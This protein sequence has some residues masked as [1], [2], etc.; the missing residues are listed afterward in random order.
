MSDDL[1]YKI[2]LDGSQAGATL[3]SLL[4]GVSGLGGALA[5]LGVAA[6][7]SALVRRGMDFNRTMADSEVAISNVLQQMAGLNAESAK[8]E[9]AKAMQQLIDLEPKAAASLTGLVDGFMATLGASQSA[10]ISVSENIDLVGRFSNALA[11]SN[12]HASQLAQEMRSIVTGTIGADSSLAK[13]LN[14]SNEDINKARTAGNLYSFLVGKIGK[15][16]EAGDTAG[17]AFSTL[18]SQ[19]D[20]L[21]GALTRGLFDTSVQGAKNLTAALIAAEPAFVA[22][23]QAGGAAFGLMG[24]A[25]GGL[26]PL[27]EGTVDATR[28][29]VDEVY[30]AYAALLALKGGGSIEKALQMRE[31]ALNAL[32]MGRNLDAALKAAKTGAEQAGAAGAQAMQKLGNA[33]QNAAQQVR[34]AGE[35]QRGD[36][37]GDGIISKREQRKLDLED[38]RAMQKAN[39]IKGFSGKRLGLDLGFGGADAAGLEGA[40]NLTG[41]NEG[42]K[43]FANL[44]D[45]GG[46]AGLK[47]LRAQGGDVVQGALARLRGGEDVTRGLGA[48]GAFALPKAAVRAN[49]QGNSNNEKAQAAA[50]GPVIDKLDEI[51]VELARITTT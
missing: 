7:L 19:V 34:A 28:A 36:R 37:D 42:K 3:K 30:G 13:V 43:A 14:I 23:G 27:I 35:P 49:L 33:A 50:Q 9:A 44:W 45:I 31:A 47:N 20:K 22:L 26:A 1:R 38:K 6:G 39:A 5:G 12:I 17:V 15:L 51:K 46:T 32:E 24:Q 18:G 8:A 21:A 25:I 11:N 4:G 40:I 48:T 10:G 41:K 29:L 2:S 16:G